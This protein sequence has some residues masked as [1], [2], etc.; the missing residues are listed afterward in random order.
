MAEGE[1]PMKKLVLVVVGVCGAAAF[2]ACQPLDMVVGGDGAAPDPSASADGT[3]PPPAPSTSAPP[4][5]TPTPEDARASQ[6]DATVDASVDSMADATLGIDASAPTFTGV[7][8]NI[9]LPNCASCHGPNDP[10]GLDL[11]TKAAAYASTVGVACT[12]TTLGLANWACKDTP[13]RGYP[14]GTYARITP[15]QPYRSVLFSKV[16]V[17]TYYN[18]GV[19]V[20]PCGDPMPPAAPVSDPQAKQLYAWILAGAPND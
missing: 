5:P 12:G 19:Q 20:L 16:G 8:Y 13:L 11:S 9:F 3:A 1:I 10:N 4:N 14:Q 7:F 18:P 6:A 2:A 17:R 15:G